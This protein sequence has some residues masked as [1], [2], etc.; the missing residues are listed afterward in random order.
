[1]SMWT[2]R[3]GRRVRTI[4]LIEA[5]VAF[6]RF[7]ETASAAKTMVRWASM[8]SRSWWK[9]GR[10]RGSDLVMRKDFSTCHTSW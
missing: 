7:R 5:P 2:V 1:M 6:C 3:R 8:A 9:I 4:F 10:A